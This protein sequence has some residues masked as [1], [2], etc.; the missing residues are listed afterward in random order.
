MSEQKTLSEQEISDLIEQ[1]K[2]S[3]A[4]V[5]IKEKIQSSKQDTEDYKLLGLCNV[6]LG[7]LDEALENFKLVLNCNQKDATAKYYMA[8]I[9]ATKEQFEEA[10]ELL[11]DV[12]SQ[13]NNSSAS[14]NCSF[15]AYIE[16]M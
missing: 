11:R 1:K 16:A 13:R 6:N 10:E 12:L 7:C 2:Y 9:Y 8:S 5:A 14:S 4:K 3:L 15:V